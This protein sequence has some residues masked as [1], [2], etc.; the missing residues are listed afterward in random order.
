MKPALRQA[1]EAEMAAAAALYRKGQLERALRRLETAH[2]LGQRHVAPHV[3]AHWWMLRIGLRR[4]A[5]GETAGQALRM[6]LGALGSA[7]GRVPT[8]NSGGTG[9]GMF[10][11]MQV[12]PALRDLLE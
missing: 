5:A 10:R 2:V 6:V 11:R 9:V 7:V 12:D 4:R 8:G 1:Y 3:L